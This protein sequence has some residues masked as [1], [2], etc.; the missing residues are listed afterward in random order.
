MY[1]VLTFYKRLYINN[2]QKG[3]LIMETLTKAK[4]QNVRSMRC[5][6]CYGCYGGYE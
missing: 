6:Y 2:Y 5:D 1:T 4:K 3:E